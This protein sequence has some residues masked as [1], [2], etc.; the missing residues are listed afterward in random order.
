M[1][2]GLFFFFKILCLNSN[3]KIGLKATLPIINCTKNYIVKDTDLRL[4]L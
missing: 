1:H 2:K 4:G 3:S